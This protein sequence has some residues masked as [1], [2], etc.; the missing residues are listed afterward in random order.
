LSAYASTSVPRPKN[1]QDFQTHICILFKC[2]L[3]DPNATTHGSE[4]QRQQG[5]DVYGS[6]EGQG[7]HWVGVQCKL[8]GDTKR[9]TRA[10]LE[11]EIAEAKKFK[12]AL[13]D[14][15]VVTTAPDD[16]KIQEV[17]RQ[18]T[19][20]H[21]EKGLFTVSVWGWQT[22]EREIT[23]HPAAVRAFHPDSTPFSGE[24]ISLG[25]E[26]VALGKEAR[27]DQ[28]YVIGLLEQLVSSGLRTEPG[29]GEAATERSSA[30]EEIIEQ[31]IHGEI[32]GYRDLL[33]KGK[34][35]T[36]KELLEDLKA[37]VWQT[38]S[39]RVRFRII[40]N[41]GAACLE[42]GEEELAANAFL[43][44]INFDSEDRI[45]MANVAL[46]HILRAEPEQA[47]AAA[48]TALQRDPANAAA[49]A[50]LISGH[51]GD[52]S[53]A[54]PFSLVPEDLR[55]SAEVLASGIS[56]LSQRGDA[57]WRALAREAAEK[58]PNE[59]ILRRRA[60]EAVLDEV[61]SSERFEL[62]GRVSG[63]VTLDHLRNAILVLQEL[64]KE[65]R[66]SE[67]RRVDTALPHNLARALWALNE[68]RAA[69]TVLDQALE[70][71]PDDQDLRELRA[72]LHFEAD[73]PDAALALVG[74]D[75][76]RP[77]L[78][79]MQAKALLK[80]SPERARQILCGRAFSGV[81]EHQ[82]LGAELL[83][84]EIFIQER[85]PEQALQHAEQLVRD[86]E[87]SVEPLV[88]LARLQRLLGKDG[89][90]QTLTRAVEKLTPET[91]FLE[92]LQVANALEEVGRHDD[93]ISV[94]ENYVDYTHGSPALRLLTFAYINA[95]RRKAA[96]ELLQNLPPEL[97]SQPPYLKT[98]VAVNV[99]RKDFPA[100][101]RAL[102]Q[103][104]A[105]VPD[106]LEMRLRWASL[107]L[108]QGQNGRV[109]AFLDSN[110]EALSGA[111]SGTR[112]MA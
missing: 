61:V 78:A 104:L 85:Q 94:L 56:F 20:K 93:V 49:A 17:A 58:H 1:W 81:P 47:I 31:N 42:L 10:E 89:A 16:A 15:I 67:G 66:V 30:A 40:T 102:D 23:N 7:K 6:R 50:Y 88:E 76:G 32:D 26:A 8:K 86:Y 77:G 111:E 41:I 73:E 38:A 99:N 54:D 5:V 11:N 65:A 97:A 37:R 27:D 28:K 108:R 92:R 55:E 63:N 3:N 13:A 14:F 74:D 107:C 12:P 34:V 57:R 79:L 59:K 62:G 103:Y 90:D 110:V 100:A 24:L 9:V 4:G 60:A 64:W 98:L 52:Q 45:G 29:A 101:L 83:V 33:R 69:A 75:V 18:I 71:T 84:V 68:S 39:P 109:A 87:W 48:E 70:R 53:V 36:A 25:E 2:I 82:K 43:E 22:L 35:N 72:A 19:Q 95:D 106:D 21:A 91:R 96:Y 112:S 105:L 44:A 46:A 51:I 80:A